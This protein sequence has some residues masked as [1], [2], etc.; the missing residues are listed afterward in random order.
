MTERTLRRL[1]VAVAV[2]AAIY[3][4]IL[5]ANYVAKPHAD[6]GGAFAAMMARLRSDTIVEATVT[7]PGGNRV[8]VRRGSAAWTVNGFPAD[9]VRVRQ[10]LDAIAGAR[11]GDLVSQSPAT[12]ERLG[13]TPATAWSVELD[14]THTAE[15]FLLATAGSEAGNGYAR[16]PNETRVYEVPALMRAVLTNTLS[17]WRDKTL[18][19]VD[20]GAVD[21]LVV[22]RGGRRSTFGRS[23]VGWET[24]DG[25]KRAL[26]TRRVTDLLSGL[27]TATATGLAPDSM[28]FVGKESRSIVVVGAHD[29]TIAAITF[30]GG[31][32]SW[33]ARAVGS[34]QVYRVSASLVDRLTPTREDLL[35][36][37]KG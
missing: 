1:I 12:L 25:G 31:A 14:G 15:R 23:G 28:R 8:D 30:V 6:T 10:L 29:D 27:A 7:V 2:L 34:R 33:L 22:E 9:T 26:D 35:A 4:A 24:T 21:R 13:V 19:H 3:L 36:G 32:Q 37:P 5:G 20:T 16:L 11:A 18:A 17:D